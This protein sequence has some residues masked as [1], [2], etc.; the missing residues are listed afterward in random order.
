M[1]LI[2]IYYFA[3]RPLDER[4]PS[5]L[6]DFLSPLIATMIF[7]SVITQYKSFLDIFHVAGFT[8]RRRDRRIDRQTD[9]PSKECK[10]ASKNHER[11]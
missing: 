3:I 1:R 7:F 10:D 2:K 8:D 9:R 5:L 11:H 6:F 4:I